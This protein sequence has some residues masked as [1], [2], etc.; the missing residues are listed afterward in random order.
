M[1]RK[2]LST[3]G[4]MIGICLVGILLGAS[5][6]RADTSIRYVQANRDAYVDSGN[7]NTNYGT[8]SICLA[9]NYSDYTKAMMFTYI[10][11]PM[12]SFLT[13]GLQKIELLIPYLNVYGASFT[14]NV[15]DMRYQDFVENTVT[16]NTQPNVILPDILGSVPLTLGSEGNITLDVTSYTSEVFGYGLCVCVNSSV[17]LAPGWM[18]IIS[19]E[20][21]GTVGKSALRFTYTVT[22][23]PNGI[24]GYDVLLLL[25]PVLGMVFVVNRKMRTRQ[26]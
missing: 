13:E 3:I 4:I 12:P 25:L 17:A 26:E 21:P 23:P 15:W 11:F 2:K 20:N 6:V 8:G 18:E 16:W 10:H 1:M 22:V 7:P 5:P 19:L 14:A 24:A 9:G